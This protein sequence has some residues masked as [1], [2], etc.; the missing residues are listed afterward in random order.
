M[1]E[2]ALDRLVDRTLGLVV[3]GQVEL[4]PT[5]PQHQTEDD[6][7]PHL[8]ADLDAVG[9]PIELPLL[10]RRGLEALGH[11]GPGPLLFERRQVVVERGR[12]A[13][14]AEQAELAQDARAD[15]LLL[16]EH[17]PDLVGERHKLRIG[18]LRPSARRGRLRAQRIAHGVA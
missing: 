18:A 7:P 6:D 3:A 2:G 13:L 11:L 15:E 14:V 17:R 10:A 5:V 12:S 16:E 9:R 8:A 1:G 4:A